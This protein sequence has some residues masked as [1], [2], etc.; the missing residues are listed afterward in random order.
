M[1]HFRFLLELIFE[2]LGA[3]LVVVTFVADFVE[4]FYVLQFLSLPVFALALYLSLQVL[5]GLLTLAKALLQAKA[6]LFMLGRH[7]ADFGIL[8]WRRVVVSWWAV[9]R[10]WRS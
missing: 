9:S 7:C 1:Q 3:L 4:A 6:G 5:Q 2:L 10:S 8:S